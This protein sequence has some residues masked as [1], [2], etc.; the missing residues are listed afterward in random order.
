M[1]KDNKKENSRKVNMLLR[2]NIEL[3]KELENYKLLIFNS[4][5]TKEFLSFDEVKEKYGISRSTLDRYRKKGLIVGQ[6]VRNGN[7]YV[8]EEDLQKF[9]LGKKR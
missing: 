9:L 5:V 2:K 7:I 3:T 4:N 6:P 1:T 8:K